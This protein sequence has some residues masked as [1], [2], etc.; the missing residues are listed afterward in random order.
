MSNNV[1]FANTENPLFGAKIWGHTS[2]L[3]ANLVLNFLNFCYHSSNKVW[4]DTAITYT[5]YLADNISCS[6]VQESQT[7]IMPVVSLLNYKSI[8]GTTQNSPAR[9]GAH[10]PAHS[11]HLLWHCA[12]QSPNTLSCLVEI[13][14]CQSCGLPTQQRYASN[15]RLCASSIQCALPHNSPPALFIL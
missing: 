6:L 9:H 8:Q 3:M 4:Y 13:Q 12:T 5:V 2:R 1:Q 15:I 14:S 11:A 10:R 7:R